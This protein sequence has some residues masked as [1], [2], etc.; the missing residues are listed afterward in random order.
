M[1]LLRKVLK[2]LLVFLV[3]VVI[4]ALA[5]GTWFVRRTWPQV[6]GTMAMAG[7]QQPVEIIRDQ[8]GV[9][10]IY[11]ENEADLFFAQGYVHAQDR[12][13]QMEFNRRIGHGT[14]SAVF[15]AA[16]L[17]F[18]RYT[19]TMGLHLAAERELAMLDA[20]TRSVLDSYAAGI[21]AYITSH[22]GRL[23]VEFQAL[24]HTPKPWTPLDTLV[25]GKVMASTLS[26]NHVLETLRADLLTKLGQPA[27]QQLM[28][29]YAYG[30]PINVPDGIQE[31]NWSPEAGTPLPDDVAELLNRHHISQGSNNWVLD[32]S[33]TA[34][35][36]PLLANDTHLG[37]GMP[38]SWYENGLHGGRF[39]TVGFTFPGVPAVIIGHNQRIAWGVT[40]LPSDVQDLYVEKLND[41]EHPTQ[42]EYMNTWHDL[43]IRQEVIEI[44]GSEPI[45]LEVGITRHG[46]IINDIVPR[47]AEGEP[48]ALRWSTLDGANLMRGVLQINLATNW[49]QFRT[50]LTFW[51]SPTQHFV[52]ADVDGNIGYHTAGDLPL[53]K[54]GHQGLFP[55]PGWTDEYEWDGMIEDDELFSVFNPPD[56]FFA[57]ANDAVVPAS[58]QYHQAYGY[59]W[60]D[61][62][63]IKRIKDHLAVTS[64]ATVEDMRAL[65]ADSFSEPAELL[66]PYLLSV[67]PQNDLERQALEQ[68]KS[69]DL[70]FETDRVGATIFQVWSWFLVENTLR[71]ELGEKTLIAYRGY[72]WLSMGMLVDMIDEPNNAWFDDRST[73]AVESRDD[74]S[75]RS[76]A[77][78]LEWLQTRHG[79]SVSGWTWGRIHT[80]TFVHQPFGQSGIPIVERIFNSQTIPA[81]GSEFTINSAWLT[82]GRSF[83]MDGGTA[84]R[85]VINLA[86][87]DDSGAINSTGQS[88]HIFHPH[89][90]DMIEPWEKVELHPMLFSR[91][92][93]EA[94]SASRLTLTP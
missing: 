49:D 37:L 7:L 65:Q 28:P 80:I 53:R 33:R 48:V 55:V 93:V 75:R 34:S 64:G 41:R 20:E 31:Y 88:E 8:W 15:G 50:A 46:P 94:S 5:G 71:D 58:Y 44:Q 82:P 6:D 56:K 76:L 70:R 2:G 35:G 12:L 92:A 10:H 24:S 43:E 84:Q 83:R 29:P 18:D 91:E 21:N 86:D 62:Y 67:T 73:D 1:R 74:I 26:W 14:L 78:A 16:T 90:T 40:D 17:P 51:D 42:Y 11:A 45:T 85:M 25:W 3:V 57:T 63:R 60:T 9:P 36:K 52:Y 38:S 72:G 23:P 32:G 89:R 19:R 69:W 54:P 87:W 66:R 13:W 27:A 39:D 61:P 47:M 81:R 79:A 59:E 77:D 30:L 4:I 68:V 22:G